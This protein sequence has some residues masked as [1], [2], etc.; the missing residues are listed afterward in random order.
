MLC[1]HTIVRQ[2][3]FSRAS[4][5]ST[6]LG[7]LAGGMASVSPALLCRVADGVARR[8]LLRTRM[9][10]QPGSGSCAGGGATAVCGQGQSAGPPEQ[11]VWLWSACRAPALAGLPHPAPQR[12]SPAHQEQAGEIT[13]GQ[14]GASDA[15]AP[16]GLTAHAGPPAQRSTQAHHMQA[17]PCSLHAA[18]GGAPAA[19]AP[20]DLALHHPAC[21]C[22]RMHC[23]QAAGGFPR[24]RPQ[25]ARLMP[26]R[27][28]AWPCSRN[29]ASKAHQERA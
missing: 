10:G 9:A 5:S 1:K 17:E 27:L 25:E 16:A 20:A 29:C 23:T 18:T 15:Q 28:Q 26:R 22:T 8:R 2:S 3:A 14:R 21:G 6:L 7:R 13:R 12:S 11:Q 4:V 24:M 19:Q